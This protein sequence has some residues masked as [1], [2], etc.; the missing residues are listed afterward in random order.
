MPLTAFTAGQMWILVVVGT[1]KWHTVVTLEVMTYAGCPIFS[2]SK[3]QTQTALSTTKAEYIALSMALRE[4]IP[5]SELLK[6][7]V[8]RGGN[9]QFKPQPFVVKLF[10]TTMDHWK[11]PNFPKFSPEPSTSIS[12]TTI[13]EAM[14]KGEK[15]KLWP[16]LLKISWLIF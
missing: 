1:L 4:Q 3:M 11:W 5:I 7:V 9:D 10:K 14:M 12:I 2:A 6:E 13:S 8:T 15:L 16:L